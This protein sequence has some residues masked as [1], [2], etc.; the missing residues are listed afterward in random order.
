MSNS[1]LVQDNDNTDF[2][3]VNL[4]VHEANGSSV[5]DTI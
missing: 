3:N 2:H 5:H 1:L 4:N